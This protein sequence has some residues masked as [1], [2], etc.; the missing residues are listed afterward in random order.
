MCPEKR[1]ANMRQRSG[2]VYYD[3]KEK[4]WIARTTVTDE[5]GKRRNVKRRG[6]N[7]SAAKEI[8]KSLVRS[9]YDEGSRAVDAAQMTFNHLADRYE[10]HYLKPAVFVGDRKVAG[11]R[12]WKHVRPRR[13]VVD[14]AKARHLD[15]GK[16]WARSSSLD[17][18]ACDASAR[19]QPSSATP[20]QQAASIG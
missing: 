17:R 7:K 8:L 19:L 20:C 3:E 13:R 11:L 10:K 9:I 5:N 4:C 15:H 14:C 12:D 1:D 6:E 18:L 2:Y 16:G